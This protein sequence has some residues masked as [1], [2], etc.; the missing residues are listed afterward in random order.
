MT[1]QEKIQE[2]TGL[3]ITAD[4]L[5]AKAAEQGMGVIGILSSEN[6]AFLW[7]SVR[8]WIATCYGPVEIDMETGDDNWSRFLA[9]EYVS[10]PDLLLLHMQQCGDAMQLIAK[11]SKALVDS[12]V[13]LKALEVEAVEAHK[14]DVSAFVARCASGQGGA[15]TAEE[16]ARELTED[17]SHE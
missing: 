7:P 6:M 3:E 17:H 8:A 4:M 12:L 2:H 10:L 15:T 1:N 13:E 5:R 11:G 14:A 9:A 16:E